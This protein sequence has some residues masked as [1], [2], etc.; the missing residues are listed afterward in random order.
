MVHC[1]I[2]S[3]VGGS[4]DVDRAAIVGERLKGHLTGEAVERE[5]IVDRPEAEKSPGHKPDKSGAPFPQVAAMET[6]QP[7]QAERPPEIRCPFPL[8]ALLVYQVT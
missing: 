5:K 8:H 6:R 2:R 3:R 7:Y 4:K 1:R